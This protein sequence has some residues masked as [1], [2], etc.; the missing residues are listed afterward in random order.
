MNLRPSS[1]PGYK[2]QAFVTAFNDAR[3]SQNKLHVS[4]YQV[5]VQPVCSLT[6]WFVVMPTF[7]KRMSLAQVSKL[8]K[9]N[10]NFVWTVLNVA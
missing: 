2:A 1:N 7:Y 9:A 4:M 10:P 3:N 6:S 5:F 8:R